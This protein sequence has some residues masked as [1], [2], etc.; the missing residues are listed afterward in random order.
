M[1]KT[2]RFLLCLLVCAVYIHPLASAEETGEGPR[3]LV[4]ELEFDFKQVKEGDVIEH[5]FK[6]RNT[7]RAV[8]NI[9]DVKTG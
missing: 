7:G 5:A 3:A 1:F 2:L 6:I 4:E 8:L 9:L